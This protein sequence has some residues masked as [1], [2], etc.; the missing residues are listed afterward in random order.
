[1]EGRVSIERIA[2]ARQR[3][4]ELSEVGGGSP[5]RESQVRQAVH[6]LSRILDEL[7]TV[8]RDSQLEQEAENES[9][10]NTLAETA[11]DGIISIDDQSTIRYVNP[12]VGQMFGYEPSEMLDKNLTV[13]MPERLRQMHLTSFRRY[14]ATG[15]RNLSWRAIELVGLHKS[16]REFP[17]EISFGEDVR[18][19]KHFFT[20]IVRDVTD[21]K[22]S[23]EALRAS[24]Q[25][26]QA[27]VDNTTALV[28][29]KDLE[30][31]YVLV[32]REYERL[33][34]IGRDQIRGRTD[35]DIH[36]R[37][38]AETF[39]ANDRQVIETGRPL[40]YEEVVPSRTGARHYVVVKFLLRDQANEPYAI[41]G[42]ATDITARIRSERQA[43]LHAEIHTAFSGLTPSALQTTLQLSA[44]AVVRHLDAAFARVWTLNDEGNILELQASAGQYTRLDGEHARVPVGQLKIGL[45]AQERKPHLT[46]DVQ[47]DERISH[48]EWAKREGMVA[49]A[50]YPLLVEE[51]LV[52][53]LAMFA[54]R[55]LEPAIL[56]AL[57]LVADT[58]AKGIERK[59][60]ENKLQE[61]ERNLRLFMET[62][63]QMLWSAAP[64]G[65]I[66]YYNQRV[67]D[68][69]GLSMDE[70]RG[71]GWI[72]PIHPDERD[73]MTKAW[74]AA[75]A[76]GVPFEFE[77]RGRRG[78]DGMYRWCV[79]SA[80]PLRDPEGRILKW[81]GSV[82][83]LHD[84]KQAQE[85]LR[86]REAELAHITRIMTMGEITSSIAHE[87]NQPLGAIVNYGSACLR[88]ITTGSA[89]L[90]DIATALSE[91]V[92]DANRASS[93]IAQIRALSKK[94]V[95]EMVAL[96]VKDLVTEILP[97][98][99]Y[100]LNARR[101]ELKTV[102]PDNL[103]PV[104][105]DRIQLQ[106]VLLNLVVNGMEAMHQIPEDRRHLSIEAES[107]V[108]EDTPFVLI[109]VTDSGI[110]LSA[111]D[112]P[113]LFEAFYTTKA[114]GMG[115]GLAI[116]RSIVEAHGGRLWAT[117]NTDAGAT[118]QFM[119]PAHIRRAGG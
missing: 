61:S 40:Q 37:D 32:N 55:S 112:Q 31:R 45:I 57:A 69:T 62:I 29:I 12:T 53:V 50:G 119:L 83:D 115:M 11:S 74:T 108:A 100:E 97:L 95:P 46:N 81:Y 13:L 105:G 84:R 43:A 25:R 65:A 58:I 116:S 106:Q 47:N 94:A 1:M 33:F 73:A 104:M 63:P 15:Q 79:S 101:I 60:A 102:L 3:L 48:P 113:R 17:V 110:G 82:V 28:F 26:L 96:E 42:I 16:G 99:R 71:P 38:V 66:D 68:Y 39:R 76:E 118:F 89:D 21:R 36:P 19:D 64:D 18:R 70:L 92:N 20:G 23:E 111:E 2:T 14:L 77:F 6:L 80:L 75:V 98:V 88:L 22:R 49:F 35:F 24:E 34:D 67:L 78:A 51:R 109:R 114:E 86:T 91:I 44:E 59:W 41:C 72:K 30:L 87:I 27:I 90:T 7:E 103:S 4:A 107:H 54:R 5:D 117:P 9:R 8:A 93:I 52:G 85:A 56:Q 10:F